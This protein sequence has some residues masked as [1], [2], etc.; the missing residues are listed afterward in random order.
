MNSF[1][2]L[3]IILFLFTQTIVQ[4]AAAETN[5]S[6]TTNNIPVIEKS[7]QPDTTISSSSAS[8]VK[9]FPLTDS[10]SVPATDAKQQ[11]S[12]NTQAETTSI[13][14]ETKKNQSSPEWDLQ[15]A[16]RPCLNR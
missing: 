7:L 16:Y 4:T 6:N 5:V 14:V 1:T 2:I 9:S 3:N 12:Q 13:A 10:N 15:S 8:T 11:N